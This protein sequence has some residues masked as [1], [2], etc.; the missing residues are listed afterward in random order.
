MDGES[1]AWTRGLLEGGVD[2]GD[3]GGVHGGSMGA[4]D[5]N[6]H[7]G[8][9]QHRLRSGSGI[10]MRFLGNRIDASPRNRECISGAEPH[11]CSQG[12][13]HQEPAR[14]DDRPTFAERSILPS[15][16]IKTGTRHLERLCEV[17]EGSRAE[18]GR[19]EVTAQS[20]GY[21]SP[22]LSDLGRVAVI[23]RYSLDEIC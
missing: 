13:R 7:S 18:W 22:K 19:G 2:S 14:S 5:D 15:G 12:V 9:G 10:L 16:K 17:T 4:V 11:Q 3:A 21:R 1:S 20:T 8:L 6:D 23:W